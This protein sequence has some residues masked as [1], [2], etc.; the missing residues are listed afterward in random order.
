MFGVWEASANFPELQGRVVITDTA[1]V[2]ADLWA[3]GW[4]R[5]AITSG[6]AP[7]PLS[8]LFPL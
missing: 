2:P 7:D 8:P 4:P 5:E 1:K 3:A 6:Q